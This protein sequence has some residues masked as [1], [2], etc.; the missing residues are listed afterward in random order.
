M[1]CIMI[2]CNL[3]AAAGT[4]NILLLNDFLGHFDNPVHL[5]NIFDASLRFFLIISQLLPFHLRC[6]QHFLFFLQLHLFQ[7]LH[8][9]SH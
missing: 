6:N 2:L 8:F 5:S 4:T 3:D 7:K 1:R 9:F